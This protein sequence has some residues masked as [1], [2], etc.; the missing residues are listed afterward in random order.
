M[1]SLYSLS[2]LFIL[3][4]TQS[5]RCQLSFIDEQLGYSRVQV[6]KSEKDKIVK[7]YFEDLGLPYKPNNLFLRAFKYESKLEVWIQPNPNDNYRLLKEYDIC[8]KS[9]WMGPKRRQ[10]DLQVPEGFY[11]I[12]EF[13]PTSNFYLSMKLNYP[14]PSDNLNGESGNL[15]GNIYIHGECETVG[16]IPIE[17]S[18]IKELYWL[19]VQAKGNGQL[20]IPVHIF[21]YKF[22]QSALPEYWH[23]VEEL[24]V[25][26]NNIRE[27]YDY[28]EIYKKLPFIHVNEDGSYAFF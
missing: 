18:Q 27:G 3:I 5:A 10:G 8:E 15:G 19:L 7:S 17:N 12:S 25:F 4:T 1:K 24:Q 13:K 28:F 16:C 14:N 21:P 23:I 9:G 26:W 20:Y 2:I 22:N 11:Y 6:A